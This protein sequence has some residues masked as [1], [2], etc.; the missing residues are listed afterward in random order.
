MAVNTVKRLAADIMDVGL[1][2]VRFKQ[3]TSTL[4]RVKEALTRADVQAL[5]KDGVVYKLPVKGRRKVTKRKKRGKGSRKG[6][7]IIPDKVK[8]MERV[9][10]QRKYLRELIESGALKKEDK[11]AVYRRI[12]SGLFRSKKAMSIYLNEAGMI[13]ESKLDKGETK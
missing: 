4:S 5:I 7:T 11:R 9:R 10:A 13:D 2:R 1:G 12:K 6:K 8:W 3:D